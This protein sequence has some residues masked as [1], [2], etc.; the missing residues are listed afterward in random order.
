MKTNSIS[1]DLENKTKEV[2]SSAYKLN[3]KTLKQ[4]LDENKNYSTLLEKVKIEVT[5]IK[6]QKGFDKNLSRFTQWASECKQQGLSFNDENTKIKALS[7]I[8]VAAELI[9]GFELRDA[10]VISLIVFVEKDRDDHK[11]VIEQILTGE[12]KT[13]TI[14]MLA[15]LKHIETGKN[16]DIA[17]SSTELAKRDA[18]D[19]KTNKFYST[20]G[21]SVGHNIDR[22]CDCYSKNIVYGVSSSFEG[23]WLREHYKKQEILQGRKAEN[24]LLIVDEVDNMFVDNKNTVTLLS[25]NF[26]G[27]DEIK[28]VHRLIWFYLTQLKENK[29]EN[30]KL[31]NKANSKDFDQKVVITQNR[32]ETVLS[33]KNYLKSRLER[34]IE[35]TNFFP[36]SQSTKN[37]VKQRGELWVESAIKAEY[38]Y[39]KGVEYKVEVEGGIGVV[40]P[41]DYSNTGEVQGNTQYSDGIHQF[42][43]LKESVELTNENRVTNFI[44]NVGFY[45]SYSKVYGLTGTLGNETDKKFL[46]ETYKVVT[47]IIPPQHDRKLEIHECTGKLLEDYEDALINKIQDILEQKRPVLIINENINTAEYINGLVKKILSDK[48]IKLCIDN[49]SKH[50]EKR[51]LEDDEIII[52]TNLSGRGTDFKINDNIESRGGLH[53]IVTYIPI[54]ERVQ[55]QAFGRAGRKGQRGSAELFVNITKEVEKLED[56]Y[57][58]ALYKLLKQANGISHSEVHSKQC[59]SKTMEA[60]LRV[61]K[62]ISQASMDSVKKELDYITCRDYLF[63]KFNNLWV[64]KIGNNEEYYKGKLFSSRQKVNGSK[65]TKQEKKD[66]YKKIADNE[67]LKK[68]LEIEWVKFLDDNDEKMKIALPE[69]PKDADIVKEFKNWKEKIRKRVESDHFVKK[70]ELLYPKIVKELK[71]VKLSTETI[72][73]IIE[74]AKELNGGKST[75]ILSYLNAF[76]YCQGNIDREKALACLNEAD[77]YIN[78]EVQLV[79]GIRQLRPNNH[80]DLDLMLH[81]LNTLKNLVHTMQTDLLDKEQGFKMLQEMQKYFNSIYKSIETCKKIRCEE[82]EKLNQSVFKLAYKP[83][84]LVLDQ[85]IKGYSNCLSELPKIRE[86]LSNI[87]KDYEIFKNSNKRLIFITDESDDKKEYDIKQTKVDSELNKLI[88][89]IRPFSFI[90][91]KSNNADIA[92]NLDEKKVKDALNS[93]LRDINK[94]KNIVTLSG[95]PIR[96]ENKVT[97]KGTELSVNYSNVSEFFKNSDIID[98]Y[99]TNQGLSTLPHLK[100]IPS[101]YTKIGLI[102]MSALCLGLGVGLCFST[103]MVG[104]P[105]AV[106]FLM[107]SIISFYDSYKA[108]ANEEFTGWE[109]TL[110]KA[111]LGITVG[112]ATA[113]I[114]HGTNFVANAIL[115]SVIDTAVE[116]VFSSI[117]NVTSN[118]SLRIGYVSLVTIAMNYSE[119]IKYGI[120]STEEDL[121]MIINASKF[122]SKLSDICKDIE[123]KINDSKES[124]RKLLEEKDKKIKKIS[125]KIK[126]ILIEKLNQFQKI[127]KNLDQQ[128]KC[129]DELKNIKNAVDT[130]SEDEIVT[131]LETVVN[132][133]VQAYT[134]EVA[135]KS[136]DSKS[137]VAENHQ[138]QQKTTLEKEINEVNLLLD[139]KVNKATEKEI[140]KLYNQLRQDI[141]ELENLNAHN[142]NYIIK[143]NDL[144]YIYTISDMRDIVRDNHI[145]L[146]KLSELKNHQSETG[147]NLLCEYNGYWTKAVSKG[148][149]KYG[150]YNNKLEIVDYDSNASYEK[151]IYKEQGRTNNAIIAINNLNSSISFESCN[152]TKLSSLHKDFVGRGLIN[153]YKDIYAAFEENVKTSKLKSNTELTSKLYEIRT[154]LNHVISKKLFTIYDRDK[155]LEETSKKIIFSDKSDV[156]IA[157][158]SEYIIVRTFDNDTTDKFCDVLLQQS[159]DRSSH[160]G[161]IVFR[162]AHNYKIEASEIQT[163]LLNKLDKSTGKPLILKTVCDISGVEA[164]NL[165]PYL[166][167]S[168]DIN[169]AQKNM[170][171]KQ[172]VYYSFQFKEESMIKKLSSYSDHDFQ[173]IYEFLSDMRQINTEEEIRNIYSELNKELKLTMDE[174]TFRK[175]L[176][177]IVQNHAKDSRNS[178]SQWKD[179][180]SEKVFSFKAEQNEKKDFVD[181]LFASTPEENFGLNALI[182]NIEGYDLNNFLI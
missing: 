129:L 58:G 87:I 16:I 140:A 168:D 120:Y 3:Q 77:Q 111:S 157:F 35:E 162:K 131:R 43:Q 11:G 37:I 165:I 26:V 46:K 171:A 53:V 28:L 47:D 79:V 51:Y 12:G 99:F 163:G 126:E 121:S 175:I 82:L 160:S 114:L 44:S 65:S 7:M 20:F 153:L 170:I 180:I 75:A 94:V 122:Q 22:N 133:T 39:K 2:Y 167:Q 112:L 155:Q 84:V 147:T 4:F 118:I 56:I 119:Q 146:I 19:I 97:F 135:S 103:G 91:T 134:A 110:L 143:R 50:D 138:K 173:T 124:E 8:Q 64:D 71:A 182:G 159:F 72:K 6:S 86:A 1:K 32:E 14:S 55:E 108:I 57:Q 30:V 83:Q 42:L 27:N 34:T 10:Q 90:S 142:D 17:T 169:P 101:F 181:I 25:E 36:I 67:E 89:L 96:G 102:S 62:S 76:L 128:Q 70:I 52:S 68:T 31:V 113:G 107:Q 92:F 9:Y 74:T 179:K 88:N 45:R 5:N 29:L 105:F 178:F 23:D 95:Q 139:N 59:T 116:S 172:S 54:N 60:L 41:V 149:G 177:P 49:K 156:D 164:C 148:G 81:G 130:V 127:S 61:T 158:N 151:Y 38:C 161:T 63:S 21:V 98:K 80:K 93:I 33:I 18:E 125:D 15:V 174:N 73:N 123:G 100:E 104:V 132:N 78:T 154:L 144:D 40:K 109:G 176:L 66:I 69:N 13:V 48:Q 141:E 145:E 150:I 136:I 117:V 137:V 152:G 166:L 106:P 85:W 115:E 24:S